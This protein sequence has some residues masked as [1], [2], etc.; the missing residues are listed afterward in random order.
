MSTVASAPTSL[1]S[2]A[3][4][5]LLGE[6]RRGGR[7]HQE[8]AEKLDLLLIDGR[9]PSGTRLPAERELAASLGVSRTTI[10]SAYRVLRERGILRSVQGSGSVLELPQRSEHG[11]ASVRGA[12]V[13][14]TRSTPAAWEELP[15]LVTEA[16]AVLPEQMAIGGVDF[17]GLPRLRELIAERYTARGAP[18][19]ADNILITL[20]AQHAIALIARTLI[21]RGDRVVVESP[22]YPHALDAFRSA[23]GRPVASPLTPTGVDI[24]HLAETIQGARPALAYLMPDFHNPTGLSMS[25]EQRERLIETAARTGTPLVIDE[26]TAELD[27]DRPTS[28]RPF[29]AFPARGATVITIGSISKTVWSGLRVGWIRADRYLIDRFAASR[30]AGDMGNTVL[31]QLVTAGAMPDLPRIL[32]HRG[33]QLG[34]SRDHAVSLLTRLLPAWEVPSIHGGLAMWVGLGAPLSSALA[35]AARSHGVTITAGPRFGIDGAFERWIRIP[36]ASP[37][38]ELTQG[39]EGL[40][41]AWATLDPGQRLVG[42]EAAFVV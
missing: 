36:I 38:A 40:A 26:T 30:P 6:W 17:Y 35:L 22:S 37:A 9:I 21:G 14:L 32:R 20:G 18:T 34:A 13:D 5:P 7:A 25:D 23:G 24:D 33:E 11:P 15:R 27:I 41:R 29:A 28:T 31:D 2:H 12:G 39:I 19:T 8:L 10:V 1:G 42:S 3:L 16:A 4:Q